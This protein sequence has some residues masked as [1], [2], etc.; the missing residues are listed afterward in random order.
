M[1]KEKY[2]DEIYGTT[3]G[4]SLFGIGF[5]TIIKNDNVGIFVFTF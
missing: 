4:V 1:L 5:F 2:S 3:Q